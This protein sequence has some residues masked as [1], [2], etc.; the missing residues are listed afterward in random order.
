[1]TNQ[2]GMRAASERTAVPTNVSNQSLKLLTAALTH[3][4]TPG[5]YKR[6]FGRFGSTGLSSRFGVLEHFS[7]RLNLSTVIAGLDTAIH[8]LTKLDG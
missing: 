6:T 5:I 8:L 1:M 4:K 7:F 2:L 3:I